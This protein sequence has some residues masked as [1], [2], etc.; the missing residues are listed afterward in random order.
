MGR[1]PRPPA[2]AAGRLLVSI[3]AVLSLALQQAGSQQAEKKKRVKRGFTAEGPAATPMEAQWGAD[4]DEAGRAEL[5]R[6]AEKIS[7]LGMEVCH[8]GLIK[9]ISR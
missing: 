5:D 6:L 4:A 2:P 7:A 8:R 9:V 3:A 1:S